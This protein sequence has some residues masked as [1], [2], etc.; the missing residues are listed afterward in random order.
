MLPLLR[1]Q[2]RKFVCK[3]AGQ[4]EHHKVSGLLLKTLDYNLCC[5]LYYCVLKHYLHHFCKI[6]EKFDPHYCCSICFDYSYWKAGYL[7]GMPFLLLTESLW[8]WHLHLFMM[9]ILR[10]KVP[11]KIGGSAIPSSS[12]NVAFQGKLGRTP[13]L[14]I[15]CELRYYPVWG[16]KVVEVK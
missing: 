3:I 4:V 10:W 12:F 7:P 11:Y 6:E 16:L 2:Q 13:R 14:S 8:R 5:F 9:T 15:N 1:Y